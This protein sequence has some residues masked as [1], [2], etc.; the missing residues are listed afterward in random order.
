VRTLAE[1]K[2]QARRL[3]HASDY[4]QTEE[5]ALIIG[6]LFRRRVTLEIGRENSILP[7]EQ[8]MIPNCSYFM[9]PSKRF[10]VP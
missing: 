5:P 10:A 4:Q 7:Q 1:A 6:L 2:H 9:L 8:P 3:P